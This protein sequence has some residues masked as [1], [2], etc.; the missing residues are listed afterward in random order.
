MVVSEK[1]YPFPVG[2]VE[3]GSFP[4]VSKSDHLPDVSQ[5]SSLFPI[6]SEKCGLY[7]VGSEIGAPFL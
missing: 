7:P 6:V 1:N 3:S 5:W 2:S 4:K